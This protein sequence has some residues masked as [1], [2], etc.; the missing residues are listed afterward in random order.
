MTP[1]RKKELEKLALLVREHIVRMSTD[2][3]CFIGASLSCADIIVY[4]YKEFLNI[5]QQNLNDPHRDYLLLSKGHDVPAL[6]G[7]FAE[8][9]W[10]EKSR[11]T[12][13]L[14]SNDSIYWHPNRQIPGIEYY[15]GSLGHLPAVGVG[16]AL[17]IK[18]KGENNR[19]VIITGDGE[20]NEGS[21]WEAVL[22][23]QAYKLDNL[24]F[25]VDRN[26]FQANVRTEELI[27]LEPLQDKFEAFGCAVKRINGHD[28]EAMEKAFSTIP[29]QPGKPSVIIADTIRGKGL[30]SIQE[31]ADRWFCNFTHEEVE[32]LL[33]ELHGEEQARITSET[34]TVR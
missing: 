11:L 2:G 29:I 28:F 33:K 14:K 12:N 19:V 32:K 26:H 24:I 4:L 1:E 13:H 17:D 23:A 18:M 7:L 25:L 34:L 15:S 10:I 6:Y 31:R 27:P 21:V 5:N 30:P 20:L 22:V 9:G 3:G 8:L 16:I